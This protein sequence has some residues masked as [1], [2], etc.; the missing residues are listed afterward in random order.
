MN[1]ITWPDVAFLF[2]G[3]SFATLWALLIIM[4]LEGPKKK[5]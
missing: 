2:I 5:P 4:Y 3:C 1:G